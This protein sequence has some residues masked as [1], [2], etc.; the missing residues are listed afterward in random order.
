[1]QENNYE[2]ALTI[3]IEAKS[4]EDASSLFI[5][6]LSYAGVFTLQGI[7]DNEREGILMVYCPNL[8]FPYARRVISDVT[9]DGGFPPL[10]MEPIDFAALYSRNKQQQKTKS[11]S[12]ESVH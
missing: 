4:S 7:D 3:N 10:M 2:L 11:P 8:L 12:E 6:E 1:L 9:R 5:V